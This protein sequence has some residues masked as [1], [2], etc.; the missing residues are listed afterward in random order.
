MEAKLYKDMSIDD[1]HS[2]TDFISKSMLSKII[3]SEEGGCPAIFKYYYVDGHEQK[4]TKSLRLGNAVHV[5]ALEPELWESSYHVLPETYFDSK[6]NEKPFRA[7][8]RMRVYK[9]EVEKAGDKTI[10]TRSEYEQIEAMA[11]S[12]AK[13]NVAS[14]L[15]KSAGYAEASIFWE[16]DGM[17]FRCRPDYMRNDGLIVDLKTTRRASP[18]IFFKDA[19]RLRYDMSVALTCRGYRAL[20]GK[21]PENY[22]FLCVET[23][24]P[25][26]VQCYESYLP[27]DEFTEL[28]Y[29]EFGEIRLNRAINTLKGCQDSGVWPGYSDKIETMKVPGWALKREI[30]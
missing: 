13:S 2:R 7:D 5:L 27:M 3:A 1:Y 28:S 11:N 15:L 4:K 30:G 29:Y 9:D 10:I 20:R 22:V 6:G 26:I 24:P 21:D 18:H 16:S 17:K 12:I 14:T 8:P 23:D 19:C 25:H